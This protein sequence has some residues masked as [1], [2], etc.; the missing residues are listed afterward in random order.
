MPEKAVESASPTFW[1]SVKHSGKFDRTLPAKEISFVSI[2]TPDGAVKAFT[3]GKKEYVA[4]IGASSV[5]V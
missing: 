3:I 1:S 4:N 5:M 2:S